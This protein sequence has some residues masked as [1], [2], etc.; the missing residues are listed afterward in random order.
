MRIVVLPYVDVMNMY[1]YY[2]TVKK[3]HPNRYMGCSTLQSSRK[4]MINMGK[5][6][7]TQ[8]LKDY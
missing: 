3:L 7:K 8:R 5:D 1:Y 4:C 2:N 6:S